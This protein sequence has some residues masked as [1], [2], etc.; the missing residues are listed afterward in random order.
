MAG[1]ADALQEA[2]NRARR[3]QL[4]HQV[5]LADVDAQ[6][7]RG[8]RHQ[9]LELAALQAPLG[10]QPVL[11]RHAAVVRGDQLLA[12]PRR[13]LARHAFGHA[14][15]VDEDE[16]GAVLLD[17]LGEA[18]V[19]LLPHLRRHHRFQRRRWHLDGEIARRDDGRC[20]QRCTR[21][22]ARPRDP[23]RPGS[24]PPC[25]SASAWRTGRCAAA[26]RRTAT[27]GAPATAPDA[28]RACWAPARGSRR[29]SR[30][31]WSRAFCART[32]SRAGCRATPASSPRCAA[33]ACGARSRSPCGVSP[34]RTQVRMSTSGRPCARSASRMPA[35]GASR[36]RWMSLDSALS[37][38]T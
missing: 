29:R 10:V 14:P 21:A 2:G 38:E 1:A 6:L 17:Q 8:R 33:G 27:Q 28:S 13:Q 5:D 23:C 7:Q 34:V 26:G 4:A 37:G 12:Q 3:A 35:S 9:R 25:R 19:D 31:G 18:F 16:R 22:A 24:V 20:R 32:P 15:R 30:C 11:L 36:L